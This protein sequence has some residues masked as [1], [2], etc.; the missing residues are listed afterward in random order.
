MLSFSNKKNAGIE[1]CSLKI[2]QMITNNANPIKVQQ[3][4]QPALE[5]HFE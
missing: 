1:I 4:S 5:T 3:G 2:I